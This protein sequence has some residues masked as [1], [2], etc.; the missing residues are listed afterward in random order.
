MSRLLLP[1]PLKPEHSNTYYTLL[2]GVSIIISDNAVED[3]K[4]W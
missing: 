3:R 1:K 4:K 2:I